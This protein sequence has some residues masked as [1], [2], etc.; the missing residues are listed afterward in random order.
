MCVQVKGWT[1][2]A[3]DEFR[4]VASSTAVEMHGCAQD[5]EFLLV[6][7][8]KAPTGCSASNVPLSLQEYLVFLDVAKYTHTPDASKDVCIHTHTHT[9][10][11]V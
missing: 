5:Q 10:T 1:A 6:D 9:H 11:P 4:R 2:E 3:T 7:L 8:K